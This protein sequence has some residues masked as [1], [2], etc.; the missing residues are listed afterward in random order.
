MSDLSVLT[1]EGR[2]AVVTGGSRGIGS[3]IAKKFAAAG[4][5]VA[6][7]SKCA[8]SVAGAVNEMGRSGASVLGLQCDVTQA[9]EV[10]DSMTETVRHFGGLDVLVNS[11]AVL[12][13][14]TIS[15]STVEDWNHTLAVNLTGTFIACQAAIPHLA[16]SHAPRIINI[17]SNAG[18]MGGFENGL[19]YTASKGGVIALTYGLARRLAEHGITVNCVAPGTVESDMSNRWSPETRERLRARFPLGRFGTSE[20]VATA[21][22]Y[23]ASEEAGFTTGAV[24]DVNGGLFMG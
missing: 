18:R 8:E 2:V 19:A 21:A 24:L 15:E 22:C 20:E 12:E 11:A 6:I 13:L 1:L 10:A 17:S 23:F 16:N 9:L 3:A 14:A 7:W 4:M 5:R